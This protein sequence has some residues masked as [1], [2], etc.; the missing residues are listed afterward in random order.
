MLGWRPGLKAGPGL[1]VAFGSVLNC[2]TAVKKGWAKP[3]VFEGSQWDLRIPGEEGI[4]NWRMGCVEAAQGVLFWATILSH[5]G[6]LKNIVPLASQVR[7]SG[8]C[9]GR[10]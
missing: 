5:L 4:F 6:G 9:L 2:Q 8:A 7:V 10:L 1:K 3:E